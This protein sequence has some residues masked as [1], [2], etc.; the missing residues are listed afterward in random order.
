MA[1]IIGIGV[2]LLGAGT[3]AVGS[4]KAAKK[5]KQIAGFNASVATAQA[6]DA[7]QRGRE[8]ED[9]LH[10]GVKKLMGAQRAG[11]AAQG[12]ELDSGSALEIQQDT[13]AQAALDTQ[14]IKLNAAREA[15]GF[16]QQA[17]NYSMGG[18]AQFNQHMGEAYGTILGG[19]GNAFTNYSRVEQYQ[20]DSQRRAPTYPSGT[21]VSDINK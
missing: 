21:Y 18:N 8:A 5:A 12:V 10:T 11:F 16:K 3:S 7:L 1:G 19:L 9:Q 14:R 15:W 4:E 20:T 17:T 6:E 2:G 13:G